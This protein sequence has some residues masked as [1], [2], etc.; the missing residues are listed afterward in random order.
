MGLENLIKFL[1]EMMVSYN[2]EI[3]KEN[4]KI[5]EIGKF[6]E[7]IMNIKDDPYL[8]YTSNGDRFVDVL[9]LDRQKLS[10]LKTIY[11]AFLK[12]GK[13]VIPQI[14]MVEEQTERI[15]QELSVK[16]GV[17]SDVIA[18]R[19]ENI[20]LLEGCEKLSN[21]VKDKNSYISEIDTL[22]RILNGSNFDLNQKM[23]VLR[24]VNERNTL[25]QEKKTVKLERIQERLKKLEPEKMP[26]LEPEIIQP[27]KED[28]IFIK[29]AKTLREK[30]EKDFGEMALKNLVA[31]SNLFKE[32]KSVDELEELL[33][34][35]EHSIGSSYEDIVDGIISLKNIELLELKDAFGEDSN[36]IEDEINLINSQLEI[37]NNY[38]EKDNLEK[39]VEEID[40]S[41]NEYE[42]AI[43]EY[44]SDLTKYKTQVLF[45]N[46]TV[47][48]DIDSIKDMETL[49]DL[50]ILLEKLKKGES[51]YKLMSNFKI[52]ELKPTKLGRQ[53]RVRYDV[54]DENTV[55]ILQVIEKKADKTRG[56]VDSLKRRAKQIPRFKSQMAKVDGRDEIYANSQ[57]HFDKLY[58]I[59]SKTA[60][61]KL[62][63]V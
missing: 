61:N 20:L 48:K 24:D 22:L 62:G 33:N 2:E 5:K 10:V 35:W 55:V 41:S 4:Q 8:L 32:C 63:G 60:S 42:R 6:Q 27:E 36:D 15:Q 7:I 57:T 30:L 49:S 54:I 37:L 18:K 25:I 19:Q 51:T 59:V 3:D 39:N 13:D 53:A 38:K 1:D 21:E 58:G 16:V 47:G 26:E 52:R 56:E 43:S 45:L 46:N 40:I 23:A 11:D 17:L 28:S 14:A 31:V 9:G 44:D 29:T 34:G 12:Y 50:F